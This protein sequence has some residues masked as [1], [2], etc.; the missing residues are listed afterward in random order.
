M[1]AQDRCAAAIKGGTGPESALIACVDSKRAAEEA[2]LVPRRDRAAPS[3]RHKW[4]AGR[5]VPHYGDAGRRRFPG[6]CGGRRHCVRPPHRRGT[7]RALDVQEEEVSPQ[8]TGSSRRGLLRMGYW[9]I[10][11]EFNAKLNG[12][13][14]CQM[15]V[16]PITLVLIHVN[17][18]LTTDATPLS[19]VGS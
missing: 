16:R 13:L 19:I 7:C 2:V 1:L 9:D 17:R 11:F 4:T 18:A 6:A 10:Q 14:V 8:W 12:V 3:K 5:L 15:R